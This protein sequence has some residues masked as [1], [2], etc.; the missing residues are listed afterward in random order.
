MS[1]HSTRWTG[2]GQG[3]PVRQLIHAL[4][5]V[6][7]EAVAG[8]IAANCGGI[9]DSPT[10]VQVDGGGSWDWIDTGRVREAVRRVREAV[11]ANTAREVRIILSEARVEWT[12]HVT[13][14]ALAARDRLRR[15]EG[16]IVL[17]GSKQEGVVGPDGR[18][19]A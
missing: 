17:S 3:S 4:A 9:L 8:E 13:S 11:D 10:D 6:G 7:C 14:E 15:I 2:P 12:V 5:A 1:I 19:L 18:A 16:R